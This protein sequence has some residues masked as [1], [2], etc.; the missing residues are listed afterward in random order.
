MTAAQSEVSGDIQNGP[1]IDKVVYKFVEEADLSYALLNYEADLLL[2]SID[3]DELMVLDLD[4]NIELYQGFV[5]GYWCIDIDCRDWYDAPLNS[6]DFRRA[7]AYAFDKTRVISEIMGGFSRPHDSIVPYGSPFCIEEEFDWHYYTN[8][9]EI[10]NQILDDLGYEIDPATGW[11][12]SPSS[13]DFVYVNVCYYSSQEKTTGAIAQAAADALNEL[14]VRVDVSPLND[15]FYF[16]PP[17]CTPIHMLVH[18]ANYYTHNLDWIGNT[19]WTEF[20]DVDRFFWLPHHFTN[21]TF[22]LYLEDLLSETSYSAVYDAAAEIQKLI[23]YNVPRLVI[24]PKILLQPYRTDKFTGLIEDVNRGVSGLWS[25]CNMHSKTG[26]SGGSV[27]I[28]SSYMTE[29]F[30]I[31]TADSYFSRPFLENLWPTLYSIGPNMELILNL[32]TSITTETHADNP[33]VSEGHT[34]ITMDIIHNATWSD[35]WPLTAEDVVFTIIYELE[36]E[37]FG[38]PAAQE[39]RGLV[40][41]AV[42]T[43]TRVV[44]EYDTESYW[45][46]FNHAGRYIIP[47]HIFYGTDGIGIDGWETW[48]PVFNESQPHV[49]C[50]P[51]IMDSATSLVCEMTKNPIYYY[52][53]GTLPENETTPSTSPS[54]TGGEFS[55]LQLI[56]IGATI[57]SSA[58]IVSGSIMIIRKQRNKN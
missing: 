47:K 40:Y 22:D 5:N 52:E 44:F 53:A 54:L 16:W 45:H 24:C 35:G 19:Y 48:N 38:N 39:L 23:H 8:Q 37:S 34:R 6:S 7:F 2:G 58:V 14:H 31:Y 50:G 41:A 49:T 18:D 21:S 32:A 56:T 46:S 11:R 9:A 30:N 33:R 26:S 10:G 12:K 4:P 27:R 57:S 3:I 13:D 36:S 17:P 51:F 55:P 15:R 43:P 42:Q 20:S 29:S 1:F 25:L 28:G